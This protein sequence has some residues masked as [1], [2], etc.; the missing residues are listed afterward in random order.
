MA[1]AAFAGA[2]AAIAADLRPLP[3]AFGL[4]LA[5]VALA[6]RRPALLCLSVAL[7]ASALAH[8]S[9]SG[10]R[11][12]PTGPVRGELTLVSDPTPDGR[13]GVTADVRLHGRRH[14]ARAHAAAAAALDDRLAGERV[15]VIGRIEPKGTTERLQLHRHLAARLQIETVVA[16]RPGHGV[17]RAANALRRTLASGAEVLPERQRALLAGLTLGDDRA[18]PADMTDAFRAAGLT[19][20]LAVSGQNV[21][22]VM[23]IAAPVLSRLRFGPR[24]AATLGLLAAF[25]LLTRFEPSVLRATTMAAVAA[26]G[27]AMGRPS[28]SLRTLALAVTALLLIDPLLASSLGFQLSTLATAGI[29]LAAAP[30]Q[31]TL[32]IPRWLSAPLSVTLAAQ[33]AVAPLLV[34]TFGPLPLASIPANLLAV[35]AAGPVM[36]W[37]LTAGLAAGVTGAP[38][39]TLLHIPT[40]ALLTWM[41]AV[42]LTASRH[43]LGQVDSWTLLPLTLTVAVALAAH[44]LP[45]GAARGARWTCALVATIALL[46]AALPPGAPAPGPVEVAI[47]ATAWRTAGASVLVL[48]GRAVDRYVLTGTREAAIA[49]VDAI[50]VRTASRRAMETTATLRRRWPGARV[51]APPD[52]TRSS[53]PDTAIAPPPGTIVGFG[54]LRLTFHSVTAD[55]LD[56]RIDHGPRPPPPARSRP[57]PAGSAAPLDRWRPYRPRPP[58]AAARVTPIADVR[59]GHGP[60]PPPLPPASPAAPPARSTA[61]R[62]ARARIDHGLRPPQPGPRRSQTSASGTVRS[63]LRCCQAGATRLATRRRHCRLGSA[64]S[65]TAVRNPSGVSGQP[66]SWTRRLRCEV[67]RLPSSALQQGCRLFRPAFPR[68]T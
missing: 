24:L 4:V 61:I 50:I 53:P 11:P 58:A 28:S 43:P 19:H 48:D 62:A 20:L 35:P 52:A 18:Q 3:L 47:G 7:L 59:I 64:A 22:F 55:R 54:A 66:A 30:I 36:V 8:A 67:G 23:V 33:L 65:T 15:Q 41:E 31:R 5:G 14:G 2:L 38:L 57:P 9:L 32:P 63:R 40:R 16:W 39:S 46:A 60:R 49:D 12:P 25:A 21:A 1:V 68:T 6:T 13:G 29:V 34:A 42:A 56:V 37:G 44:R 51:F 10:L 17:T 26:T 45:R 27:A